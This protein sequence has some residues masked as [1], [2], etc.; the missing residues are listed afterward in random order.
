[1]INYQI[2]TKRE[3]K[4]YIESFGKS[5]GYKYVLFNNSDINKVVDVMCDMAYENGRRHGYKCGK[6]DGSRQGYARGVEDGWE[7]RDKVRE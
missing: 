7:S 5:D 3:I 4:E 1:M 6:R 2:A